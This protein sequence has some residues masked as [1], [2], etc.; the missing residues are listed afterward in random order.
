MTTVC[1][2]PGQA[3][4]KKLQKER[5]NLLDHVRKVGKSG[6]LALMVATEKAIVWKGFC[7]FNEL[8]TPAFR[9]GFRAPHRPEGRGFKPELVL[10]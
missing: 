10:R 9:P 6:D 5:A 3:N 7:I 8:E 2:F 1:K 4:A